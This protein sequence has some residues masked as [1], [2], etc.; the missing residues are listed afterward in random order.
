MGGRSGRHGERRRCCWEVAIFRTM[1]KT[2]RSVFKFKT[3]YTMNQVRYKNVEVDG[4]RMFYREAGDPSKP[5]LLLL[6]GVPNASSAFQD[7]LHDLAD[8]LY[9]V[10]PDFPGFGN[11]EAPDQAR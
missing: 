10:A 3:N 11:S 1:H 6:N 8:D 7:L 2:S 5:A 9:L 4:M